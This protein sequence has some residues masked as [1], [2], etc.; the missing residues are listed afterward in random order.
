M[1]K[2]LL[3][4]AAPSRESQDK[5]RHFAA[6]A[7]ALGLPAHM[8]VTG[9]PEQAEAMAGNEKILFALAC[10]DALAVPAAKLNERHGCGGLSAGLVTMLADKS[11]GIPMLSR[12]LGL[13]L[14]PQCLPLTP[15]DIAGW[16]WPG[17][18]I[19]KPTRSSGAWSPRPWGYRTFAGT[20][21]FLRWLQAEG[22]E[23]AFFAEQQ[24][25][26]VLGPALLQAALDPGRLETAMLLLTGSRVELLC[27]AQ[28]EFEDTCS[29]GIGPRWRRV[30][31][32]VAAASELVACLAQLEAADWGRGFLYLQGLRSPDGF[33]LIDI[34]LR[35]SSAWDWMAAATDASAHRRLLAALLFDAPLD[36]PLPATAI[37]VDL[38]NGEA[39]RAIAALEHPP[40]PSHIRPVRLTADDCA[41]IAGSFDKAGTA[42]AFVTLAEDVQTCAA[43]A[44]NFRAGI[45]L[46]YATETEAA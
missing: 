35:L 3:L 37:A 2:P 42:P 28:A 1:S 45:R 41:P 38:V 31:Y 43:R 14:L 6:A 7:A 29:D 40:L 27:T 25:P 11:V 30:Q 20:D 26:G 22:L 46:Q 9:Q 10:S 33:H 36:L 12:R 23:D 4:L 5:A 34:N 8:I 32:G 13:P 44:E 21:D 15:D 19:V 39:G 18:I 16:S 17:R 24:R